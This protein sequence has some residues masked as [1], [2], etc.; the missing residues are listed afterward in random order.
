VHA[1]RTRATG[2]H[3]RH[4]TQAAQ[5]LAQLRV[6]FAPFLRHERDADDAQTLVADIDR[7]AE[8]QQ[9]TAADLLANG[10]LLIGYID[11][12]R[13]VR[14]CY[15]DGQ[16]VDHS[17]A[18]PSPDELKQEAAG[19]GGDVVTLLE[20]RT[21]LEQR[22]KSICTQTSVSVIMVDNTPQVTTMCT[23]HRT[24]PGKLEAKIS[25]AL[26][27]RH[28][29]AAADG[30]ANARAIE[31][32]LETL[33]AA[34]QADVAAGARSS[35]FGAFA[36]SPTKDPKAAREADELSRRIYTAIAD[37]DTRALHALA[38]E[39]KL[40]T[41][42]DPEGR[43]ALMVALSADRPDAARTLLAIDKGLERPDHK[44]LSALHY[45]VARADLQSCASASASTNRT[46]TGA[47]PSWR[48]PA[49]AAS[50]PSSSCSG[51][52][53]G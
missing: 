6:H 37:N 31:A 33:E 11:L 5:E 20:E 29:P 49:R 13:N 16:C 53:R 8:M 22:D 9:K 44:G 50:K 45:A 39:G 52:G 38:R 15:D 12:R 36:P 30:E 51:R 19:R 23:A 35:F 4:R 14:T 25:R 1:C 48:P 24:V 10:Y 32:A 3:R 34:H 42:T 26:I 17:E 28:D 18:L 41:W 2:L 40:E 21:V 43:S 7:R 46:A 47:R 27:W